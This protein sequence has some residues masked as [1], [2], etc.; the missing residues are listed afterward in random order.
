MADF[1]VTVLVSDSASAGRPEEVAEAV[2]ELLSTS[3]DF[4]VRAAEAV[5]VD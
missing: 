4:D 2:Y 5:E 3:E 1:I